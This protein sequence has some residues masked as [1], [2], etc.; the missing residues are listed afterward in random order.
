[1]ITLIVL[2]VASVLFPL[3]QVIRETV[4]VNFTE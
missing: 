3:A 1:M 2:N 4:R